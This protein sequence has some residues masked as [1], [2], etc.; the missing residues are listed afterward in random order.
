MTSPLLLPAPLPPHG[1]RRR[2]RIGLLGGS[3]NPAHEGHRHISLAALRMLG[4]DEVWWLVAPQNPLKPVEETAPLAER[5]SRARAEARHPRIRPTDIERRL[6]TRYTVNTLAILRK[7][8]PRARFVW[9]MG[10]DNLLQ[11]PRWFRW[12]RLFGTVPIAVLPRS[13][14]SLRALAGMAARRYARARVPRRRARLLAGAE[15][16]AWLFLPL[17]PHPAS[18]TAIRARHVKI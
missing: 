6:G 12:T 13:P 4:L 3:F 1:D 5:L 15:P 16:P 10:S 2:G 18:S 11:I 14:Y 17:G 9:L 7:R 8:F